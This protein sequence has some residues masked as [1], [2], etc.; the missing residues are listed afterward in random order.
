MDWQ[1]AFMHPI[2]NNI[3]KNTTD[4]L[5]WSGFDRLDKKKSYLFISNH[6]DILLDSA[7]L[8]VLLY[9]NG[10]ETSQITFGNNLM[11]TTFVI[12][13]GK[14]NKMFTVV[15]ETGGREF[16]QNSSLLSGYIRATISANQSIWIAQRNGRTK[17]GD[18][19]THN[20]LLKMLNISGDKNFV[21][22]FRELNIVP[23]AVSYEY[24]PCDLSK[25]RESYISQNGEYIKK[26]GEDIESVVNGIVQYKGHIHLAL[27]EPL[28]ADMDVLKDAG[29]ENEK[30]KILSGI[31]DH[32]IYK[33]FKLWPTHYAA[34]DLLDDSLKYSGLY[35]ETEKNKFSGHIENICGKIEGDK[36]AIR[37]ILLNIYAN[38]VKN[39]AGIT[40]L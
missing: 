36:N 8:Q 12:D 7:I 35:T 21:E 5:S 22:N 2:V 39:A 6:R 3:V 10:L 18:D 15:R 38:P 33:N 20:G 9:D 28:D 16:Y 34:A 14:I 24:E 30:I 23:M 13:V 29:A 27:A 4:G 25:A 11:V 31:I 40:L 1:V 32:E 37:N 19:K 26:R 17:D